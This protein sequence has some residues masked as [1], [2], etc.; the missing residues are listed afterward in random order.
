MATV[1]LLGTAAV[2]AEHYRR[3]NNGHYIMRSAL[4]KNLRKAGGMH[5]AAALTGDR[6]LIDASARAFSYYLNRDERNR[7][8]PPGLAVRYVSKV[9]FGGRVLAEALDNL[10]TPPE[11]REKPELFWR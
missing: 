6:L 1:G 4:R 11:M 5:N 8:D 2:K 7:L 10:L 9:K 3:R